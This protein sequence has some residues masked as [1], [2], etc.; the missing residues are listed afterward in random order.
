MYEILPRTLIVTATVTGPTVKLGA[1]DYSYTMQYEPYDDFNPPFEIGYVLGGMG[2]ADNI[3]L[4][5]KDEILNNVYMDH[6]HKL[7]PFYPPY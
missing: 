3:S 6:L 7:L 1:N 4:G 2:L 5:I